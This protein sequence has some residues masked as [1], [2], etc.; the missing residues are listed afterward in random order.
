MPHGYSEQHRLVREKFTE[1]AER[2]G[3]MS[4][5]DDLREI[6]DR[7]ELPP[8]ARVLDVAA[9]SGLL[10]RA[11]ARRAHEVVAVDITSAML[12]RGREAAERE[13][14]TNIHFVEAPA[15]SLPFEAGSF[16]L[17]VTRFSLHHISEPQGV[18]NEMVRVARG[19]GQVLLIDMLVPEERALAA[20]AN[21]IEQLRDP[22]HAWTPT[23]PQLQGYLKTAGAAI[24]DAFTQPR[25]RDLEEWIAICPPEQQAELRSAFE[26]ELNGSAPTGL[27]AYREDGA[28]RFHHPL[29]IVVARA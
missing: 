5:P 25:T 22:S 1:Q 20:R 21:E 19:R 18:V 27:Q 2:W 26:A 14:I 23:W 6:L 17:V 15:E 9:G 29:G 16:D 28:I 4:V 8:D 10:S 24:E 13:G 3:Q 11:L 12:E 7:I